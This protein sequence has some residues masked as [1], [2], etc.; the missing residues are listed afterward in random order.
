MFSVFIFF[1]GHLN[2]KRGPIFAVLKGISYGITSYAKSSIFLFVVVFLN[3][4]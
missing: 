1:F 3:L 2:S 4:I